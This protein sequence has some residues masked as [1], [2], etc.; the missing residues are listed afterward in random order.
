MVHVQTKNTDLGKFLRV[1]Q[2]KML[3]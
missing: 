2:W 1:L 3:V